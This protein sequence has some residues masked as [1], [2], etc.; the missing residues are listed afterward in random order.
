MVRF[1]IETEPAQVQDTENDGE[2]SDREK[3][4]EVAFRAERQAHL[5]KELG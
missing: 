2:H 4:S 1:G 3:H 5:E